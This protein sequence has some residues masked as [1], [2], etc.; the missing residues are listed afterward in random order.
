MMREF[1]LIKRLLLSSLSFVAF[2]LLMTAFS[3]VVFFSNL[4]YE[5]LSII[6]YVI[7]M[8]GV[9]LS[10]FF[11]GNKLEGRGWLNG[12]IGG[13]IFSVLVFIFCSIVNKGGFSFN[14][15]V[16]SLPIIYVVSTISGIIGT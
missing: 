9:A 15:F 13:V 5:I 11:S 10:G 7:L 14:S 2:L 16:Q 6:S 1:Q 12:L 4:D 3:I 8:L